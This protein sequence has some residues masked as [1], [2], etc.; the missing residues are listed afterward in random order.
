M[1]HEERLK[2]VARLLK[3]K[4]PPLEF[5]DKQVYNQPPEVAILNLYDYL[6][7]RQQG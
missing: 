7:D 5:Y 1:S 4:S 3:V 2:E 6:T